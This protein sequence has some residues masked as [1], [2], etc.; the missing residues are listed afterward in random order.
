[1]KE[2]T[3]YI[4]DVC[5]REYGTQKECAACEQS[6]VSFSIMKPIYK[7]PWWIVFNKKYPIAIKARTADGDEYLYELTRINGRK[8]G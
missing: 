1:M 2:K 6:H 3:T 4:C 5:G 7:L 8:I